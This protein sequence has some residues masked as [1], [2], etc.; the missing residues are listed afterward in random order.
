MALAPNFPA[1]PYVYVLYTYD[2]ILGGNNACAAM[3]Y[4]G[5]VLGPLSDPTWRNC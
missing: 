4:S 3:G 1:N 2:H 5:C